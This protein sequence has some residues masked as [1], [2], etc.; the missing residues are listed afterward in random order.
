M[1]L[2][3]DGTECPGRPGYDPRR[4]SGGLS[5]QVC[6][7]ADIKPKVPQN[8]QETRPGIAASHAGVQDLMR[9][10]RLIAERA[11]SI[12]SPEQQ[13]ASCGNLATLPRSL[14]HEAE[15][16]ILAEES[17]AAQPA[18]AAPASL[19]GNFGEANALLQQRLKAGNVPTTDHVMR[20]AV[21]GQAAAQK[22][23][24]IDGP[25][26]VAEMMAA[27]SQPPAGEPKAAG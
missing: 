3:K 14:F 20:R 1:H 23:P 25:A 10:K 22:R 11:F 12:A 13:A 8:A 6:Q 5:C 16:Q 18:A 2:R 26:A 27:I 15:A 24:E 21:L 19:V 17:K 7:E 9:R 4:P